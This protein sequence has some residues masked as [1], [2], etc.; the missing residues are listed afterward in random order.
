MF[1][2]AF[3]LASSA[4]TVLA[5]PTSTDVHLAV[6]PN[7]GGFS[8]VPVDI[9]VGLK[10]L[11]SYTTIVSFG[12]SYTDGGVHDGSP[13]LPAILD[14]PNPM[15]GGRVSNGPIWVENLATSS[16]AVLK[17][18][19]MRG[20]VINRAMWPNLNLPKVNDFVGQW[21]RLGTADLTTIAQ[22]F[23]Y[24]ILALTSSP[25]FA[26]NILVVDNYGR[27]VKS[28][29]GDVYKQTVFSGL[30]SIH[31]LID[32]VNV[33]FADLSRIWDGVLG[34]TPGYKS[35]GYTSPAACTMNDT[36]TIGSCSD[37]DHTFYWIPNMPSMATH[38][39]MADYVRQVL[40]QC[41]I[42]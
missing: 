24:N 42:S 26:R 33:A 4:L 6:G 30:K 20:A 13:L 2:F 19:A 40:S 16:G 23:I 41:Q 34:A 25:I 1:Q 7:C 9:N 29:A 39:I 31:T 36:T 15:A 21:K 10:P 12:D 27:G 35:F 22:E 28:P 8:G 18:Y 17:D 37:P 3:F 14:P 38:R 5:A 11:Q 32:R